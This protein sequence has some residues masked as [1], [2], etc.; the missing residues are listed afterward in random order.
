MEDNEILAKE[1]MKAAKDL[2]F[3]FVSPFK[4]KHNEEMISFAGLVENFGSE[5]GMLIFCSKSWRVQAHANAAESQGYGF[6]CLSVPND[7]ELYD[8]QTFIDVLNDWGWCNKGEPPP[9]WYTG[10]PWN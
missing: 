8:K 2:G 3:S 10:E 7:N 6:S 1:W 4:I 5:K 9:P